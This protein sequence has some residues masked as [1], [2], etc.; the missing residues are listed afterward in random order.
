MECSCGNS[1]HNSLTVHG[2]SA[3]AGEC[4]VNMLFHSGLHIPYRDVDDNL[5]GFISWCKGCMHKV[6]KV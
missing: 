1:A 5:I 4:G 2:W 6:E 3:C